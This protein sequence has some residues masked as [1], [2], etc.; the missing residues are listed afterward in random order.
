[1]RDRTNQL[2]QYNFQMIQKRDL[3]ILRSLYPCELPTNLY[4]KNLG[5]FFRIEQRL[6]L[7]IAELQ[8]CC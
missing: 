8:D 6:K 7:G 5:C 3:H 2:F 4:G 1:M